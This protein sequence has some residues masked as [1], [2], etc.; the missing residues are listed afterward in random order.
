MTYKRPENPNDWNSVIAWKNTM[1]SR[2]W[3]DY[4]KKGKL[5]E[6]LLGNTPEFFMPEDGKS[7]GSIEYYRWFHNHTLV[8]KRIL[9]YFDQ[10]K[11]YEELDKVLIDTMQNIAKEDS[12]VALE[13]ISAFIGDVYY[14][15]STTDDVNYKK[16]YHSIRHNFKKLFENLEVAP[17]A[18]FDIPD[19]YPGKLE[20]I[21]SSTKKYFD[22]LDLRY[23]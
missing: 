5:K 7:Q 3:D 17:T 8:T 15:G 9:R 10:K 18:S 14:G 1:Q 4:I 20:K 19:S 11:M 12:F 2:D 21:I 16:I 22:E 6:M 23:C 13:I